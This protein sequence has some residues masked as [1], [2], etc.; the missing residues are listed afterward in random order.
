MPGKAA[1]RRPF[2]NSLWIRPSALDYLFAIFPGAHPQAIMNRT[3]G[4]LRHWYCGK[5][6]TE[7][8][9]YTSPG[10]SPGKWEKQT[11]QGLKARSIS[12]F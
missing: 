4:A 2:Q 9:F 1:A 5:L 7:G 12:V 11:S 3:F 6:S 8:A 10:Q